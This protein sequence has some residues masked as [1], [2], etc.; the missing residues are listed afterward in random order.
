MID[1]AI[2]GFGR[3]V[4]RHLVCDYNGTLARDGELL[5]GVGAR[6]TAVAAR[7]AVH[8]LTGDTFG[9]AERALRGLPC[10]VAILPA[11]G[12]VEA[13]AAFVTRLGAADVVAIGNGRNDRLML[14]AAA[15]GIVVIGDEGSAAD[16]LQASDIV[17]RDV[18]DAFALLDDP[19][20]LTATL[21][22]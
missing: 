13:K 21:R 16:T 2:P 3:L 5:D 4:L 8:V 7:L 14:A 11:E 1:I 15:L 6:L 20:R 12:Q 10:Q 9:T 17:V 22:A 18:I 19:R